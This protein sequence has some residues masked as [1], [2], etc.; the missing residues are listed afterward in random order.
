MWVGDWPTLG[1]ALSAGRQWT[2]IAFTDEIEVTS[3][4]QGVEVTATLRQPTSEHLTN[5]RLLSADAYAAVNWLASQPGMAD[6]ALMSAKSA[7]GG[8]RVLVEPLSCDALEWV[9]ASTPAHA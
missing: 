9:A 5:I 2:A 3:G 7:R 4:A 8:R 1:E 6:W